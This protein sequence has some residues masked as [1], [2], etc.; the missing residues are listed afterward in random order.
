MPAMPASLSNSTQLPPAHPPP[1]ATSSHLQP[2]PA[3]SSRLQPPPA[4]SS[5]L[6]PPSDASR[7]SPPRESSRQNKPE[8]L[9]PASR[10][11]D[12]GRPMK[13][14]VATF[15]FEKKRKEE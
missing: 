8:A 3:A 5:R 6:Q 4:T 9:V 13:E 10:E 14:G 15:F 2:P 7:G 12:T 1:P 11:E